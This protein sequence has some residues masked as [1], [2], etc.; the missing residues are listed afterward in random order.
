MVGD[1]LALIEAKR[2]KLRSS[3]VVL[4][5]LFE[6]LGLPVPVQPHEQNLLEQLEW[7]HA[8]CAQAEEIGEQRKAC[9][10]QL[11]QQENAIL[12]LMSDRQSWTKTQRNIPKVT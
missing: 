4:S 2:N 1:E 6:N 5:K 10:F 7:V 11:L 12:E 9:F 3:L 8:R